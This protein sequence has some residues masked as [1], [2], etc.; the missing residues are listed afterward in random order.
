MTKSGPKVAFIGAGSTVF[1]RALLRDLFT[2]PELHGASIALM[3]IDPERLAATEHVAR[4]AAAEAGA[5]PAI[6]ATTD[7]RP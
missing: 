2:F 4:R 3:D 6:A 5:A 7:R 1:A